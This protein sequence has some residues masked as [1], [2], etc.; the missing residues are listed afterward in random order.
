MPPGRRRLHPLLLLVDFIYTYAKLNSIRMHSLSVTRVQRQDQNGK[1]GT[2][3]AEGRTRCETSAKR[4]TKTCGAIVYLSGKFK[5]A[6][7]H[8]S[9]SSSPP[10]IHRGVPSSNIPP[11]LFPIRHIVQIIVFIVIRASGSAGFHQLLISRA[12]RDARNLIDIH[13]TPSLPLIDG[14]F[15]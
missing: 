7:P 5:G 3:A 12:R 14:R 4:Q 2:G 11:A 15:Q 10:E 9:W 6:G 8:I 1:H 13:V